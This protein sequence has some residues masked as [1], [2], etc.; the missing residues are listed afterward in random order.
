[1][2]VFSAGPFIR[3]AAFAAATVFA[4]PGFAQENTA[5]VS[6]APIQSTTQ[7][8]NHA[9]F[10][11]DVLTLVGYAMQK[12]DPAERATKTKEYVTK[13]QEALNAYAAQRPSLFLQKLDVDGDFGAK[14]AYNVLRVAKEESI[15]EVLII[16]RETDMAVEDSEALQEVSARLLALQPEVFAENLRDVVR[17]VSTANKRNIQAGIFSVRAAFRYCTAYDRRAFADEVIAREIDEV[18]A[19]AGYISTF[20]RQDCARMLRALPPP[21]REKA[22]MEYLNNLPRTHGP[23]EKAWCLAREGRECREIRL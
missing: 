12:A 16:P 21:E 1:M 14:T 23:G 13:L 10:F 18:A 4:A 8:T 7:D 11:R 22:Q 6:A 9:D 20:I 15:H 3:R 2:T 19:R 17:M 5:P